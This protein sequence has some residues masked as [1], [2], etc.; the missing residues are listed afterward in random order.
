[1]SEFTEHVVS[2]LRALSFHISLRM[3]INQFINGYLTFL[4]HFRVSSVFVGDE[5]GS[6]IQVQVSGSEDGASAAV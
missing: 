2:K 4:R 6:G 1:M 5:R 3:R